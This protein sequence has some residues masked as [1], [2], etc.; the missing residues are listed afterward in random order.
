MTRVVLTLDLSQNLADE[1]ILALVTDEV[2]HLD[3][4]WTLME[5]QVLSG[6]T[7]VPTA[8]VKLRGPDGLPRVAS[9]VGVGPVD[10]A[11]KVIDSV[12]RVP[13]ELADFAMNAVTGGIEALATTR[14][15]VRPSPKL[16]GFRATYQVC[17]V[18]SVWAVF[19]W[20]VF[21]QCLNSVWAVFKQCLDSV[22]TSV[23]SL[24]QT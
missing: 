7:G 21:G 9:A 11:Y 2:N 24:V 13:C 12:V 20:A 16:A 19:V 18:K 17:R 5:L 6:T 1:D 10:A 14:V 23:E 15:V 3:A 8:T 22:W 4:V